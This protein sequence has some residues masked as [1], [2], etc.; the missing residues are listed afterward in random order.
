[1]LASLPASSS[2]IIDG[3]TLSEVLADIVQVSQFHT[4]CPSLQADG[5]S[6]LL[7]IFMAS[8]EAH[9]VLPWYIK[10]LIEMA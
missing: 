9:A 6:A 7:E 4:S 10:L 1:M 3:N 8:L 2:G 5:S